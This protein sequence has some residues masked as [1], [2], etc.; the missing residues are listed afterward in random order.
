M[1]KEAK[2]S[3]FSILELLVQ[4]IILNILFL[5]ANLPLVVVTFVIGLKDILQYPL[6]LLI[7]SIPL[8]P[9]LI[10]LFRSTFSSVA[11]KSFSIY[12][13]FYYS[14]KSSFSK[15]IVPFLL[16]QVL[17]FLLSFD[18]TAYTIFPIL[19]IFSPVYFILRFICLMALPFLSLELALFSN[20]IKNTLKNVIILIFTK[21]FLTIFTILYI[22]FVL[23]LINELPVSLLFFT[24]S[25]FAFLFVSFDFNQVV[26]R[27]NQSN[28][29]KKEK[30]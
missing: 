13:N 15:D 16:I 9:S 11:D 2:L 17:L 12:K 4:I 6:L 20:S 1:N 3:V 10:A 24:F 29:L 18:K 28:I 21:P 19:A 7:C 26:E 23:I 25:L 22:L 5:A 8:G 14:Y 27:I 30:I